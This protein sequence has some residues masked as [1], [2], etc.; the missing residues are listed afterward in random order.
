MM[1][2][3][4]EL[5]HEKNRHQV[6]VVCYRKGSRPVAKKE[7]DEIR[8]NIIQ[9]YD[10]GNPLFPAAICDGCH[11]LLNRKINGR[12]VQIPEVDYEKKVS[13]RFTR[14]SSTDPCTCQICVVATCKAR[15]AC[16]LKKKRGRPAATNPVPEA[17]FKLCAHCLTK[18][19]RG[20]N[21]SKS[22]CSSR[23]QKVYNVNELVNS[24]V[25][26]QRVASKVIESADGESIAT[27]GPYR[28]ETVLPTPK[29]PR[30]LFSATDLSHIQKNHSLSNHQTLLLAEDIRLASGSRCV[31]ENNLRDNLHV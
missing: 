15:A 11:L 13:V 12:N 21:H 2:T 4:S 25:T 26:V 29:K 27:L 1:E 20:C 22:D 5:S 7:A 14:S 23:R 30:V 28:K 9:G 17:T 8:K 18:L 6:C 19:Y 31:I 10:V 24:P 16:N 3:T